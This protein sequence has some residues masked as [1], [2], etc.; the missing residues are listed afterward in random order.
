MKR[1]GLFL[2]TVL[3]AL[4]TSTPAAADPISAVITVVSAI[5]STIGSAIAAAS[6][7]LAASTFGRI[8]LQVG[9]QLALQELF[10]P[11]RSSVA[12]RQALV[13]EMSLGETPREA[14]FGRCATGGSLAN[15]WNDGPDND[16]ET[17]VIVLADHE[18][19]AIEGFYLDDKYYALTV[20]GVQ[21]N[22]D[23]IDEAGDNPNKLF[24]QWKLGAP[25]AVNP[26]YITSEGVAAGEWTPTE[27]AAAFA[28]QTIVV[29][30]YRRDDEVWSN[31]RP[32][33]RWVV[34]G[35]KCYDPRKD[36]TVTGG[37]GAHR[38]GQPTT[39]EWTDNAKVCHSNYIWGV[40]N[41]AA[42]PPQLMV[43]P[44]KSFEEHPAADQ[45]AAMNLCDEDVALKAGGTEKRYRCGGVI[46]ADSPW[47]DEEEHFA[48]AMGG[49][50]VERAGTI[51]IDPGVAKAAD[52]T[53]TDD[54]LLR[55]IDLT[56]RERV[57]RDKRVNTVIARYADP[58]QLY[59][60]TSAPMRRSLEDIA[61]DGEV[62]DETID[63]VLVQSGTQAQR[64][65]EIKRRKNR[66]EATAVVALGPSYMRVEDGD[67]M[68][69]T[70]ARRF[71]GET[72]T[73]EA[74]GVAHDD[75][76]NVRV[77]LKEIAASVF[78]WNP[79]TDELDPN[80]PAYLPP[81]ALPAA[82][83]Q[84]FDAEPI[85]I[86]SED[87]ISGG[88]IRATW[89]PPADVTVTGIRLEYRP[90]GGA[91]ATSV[92]VP[93]DIVL[94]GE[95]VIAALPVVDVDYEVRA[96]PV[97]S[98]R[99]TVLTTAWR[100]VALSAP[101]ND[102]E[103]PLN[104]VGYQQGDQIR[105]VWT[106]YVDTTL[107]Y[108]IRCGNTFDLGRFVWRGSGGAANV[109]W[110][111]VDENDDLLFWI[112]TVHRS[113][114]YSTNAS[115]WV[116][117]V[118]EGTRNYVLA[119][120]FQAQ[121]FPGVLHSLSVANIGGETVLELLSE[122]G[123]GYSQTRGDYYT[124]VDLIASFS[125]R[126]WLEYR[127]SASVDDVPTWE[128]TEETWDD[129]GDDDW[130]P[131][132]ADAGGDA[133]I[134]AFIALNVDLSST[135]IEGFRFNDSLTGA[136]GETP[137]ASSSITY[138][139]AKAANGVVVAGS[140][141]YDI[142]LPVAFSSLQDVRLIG[143]APTTDKVLVEFSNSSGA[144]LRF[145]WR[146]ED[147]SF[148]LEGN[149]GAEVRFAGVEWIDDDT[150]SLSIWQSADARGGMLASRR[151]PDPV[152]GSAQLI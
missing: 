68:E 127:A 71:G 1:L 106:Q 34:K 14:I 8:L 93:R 83:V 136:R 122:E 57:G 25:G 62:R 37:S 81:A 35:L 124:S 16:F 92:T 22:P 97:V 31:G 76:G 141:E 119:E 20:Q 13:L 137:T 61:A 129:F 100:E 40:W 152:T 98:P 80:Q 46:R 66:L 84:D 55:G 45:I 54:Q 91:A 140:L 56:Y 118:V 125:A 10:A 101:F 143:P 79:A 27:A 126:T 117:A 132:I 72:R 123:T 60:Q 33:F 6:A 5:A 142:D 65:A 11:K 145:A 63:L 9:L 59:E 82:E 95:Y 70:S 135:L 105:F 77:P 147:E 86:T 110:P 58:N 30:R 17:L 26:S 36:S 39:Y 94:L 75:S 3:C 131:E 148:V 15:A 111:I 146:A 109:N 108:E 73:F 32:R 21:L 133:A 128:G 74:Q 139:P 85:E 102:P 51:G 12:E 69:W 90:K 23:F 116:A 24:I 49:Q 18:C 67:W 115:L 64:I 114:V 149:F 113:G 130:T 144:W 88:A 53:F 42:D 103:P 99:R 150:L 121:N 41:Y 2:A 43:G 48:A 107:Q 87:G 29:A 151:Q 134:D 44:G 19:T 50:L 78:T 4:L 38:W 28:G 120:D 47:I 138:A 7:F 104:F 89:T 52:F 96:T 112:K